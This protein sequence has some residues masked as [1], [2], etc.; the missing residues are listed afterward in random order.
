MELCTRCG[1]QIED[2]TICEC[3]AEAASTAVSDT[4]K[5]YRSEIQNF[6][7][8]MKNRMGLDDPQRNA[9]DRYERGQQIVPDSINPNEGEVPVRQYNIAVL[10][11]LL[12][13]ERAEG[14]LQVTNKR[15]VFRASGISFRGRTTLHQEYAID[16]IAGI[17]ARNNYKLNFL[18]FIF[19][20]LII[21]A[22]YFIISQY[23]TAGNA[24]PLYVQESTTKEKESFAIK[25]IRY[26]EQA[27]LG[28]AWKM[29]NPAYVLSA[30]ERESQAIDHRRHTEMALSQAQEQLGP[31]EE[32]IKR[33]ESDLV[34][35]IL[36]TRRVAVG[37]NFLGETTYR[38]ETY[39]DTSEEAMAEAEQNLAIAIA[40][41]MRIEGEIEQ[42]KA[43]V[44]GAKMAEN[45]AIK[46]RIS[47]ERICA[48]LMTI[49]GILLGVGCIIPF[50]I[51]Y[52]RFGLKLF[53]LCF[54]HFGFQ[55][56]LVASGAKIFSMFMGIS[57]IIIIICMFLFFFRPN[58]VISILN[59]VGAPAAINVRRELFLLMPLEKGIGFAEVIP[60]EESESAIREIC[61]IISD[62]QKLGDFGIE[63]WKK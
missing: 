48:V 28:T 44:T 54:S 8:S 43:N 60:T 27:G 17:E 39:R 6:W 24:N 51:M 42:A 62:I 19:S 11:N 57:T 52:K 5:F 26:R 14:R 33:A 20:L 16:E 21:F 50:F 37:R 7:E 35:G 40:E 63:K 9:S 22:A 2:G 49:L 41:K 36:R 25:Y 59:K 56:S 4:P 61:A 18:Y 29:M 23:G 58:L 12:R 53:I 30:R 46:N 3:S 15:V 47:T 32:A 38:N 13:L 45:E 10:R 34:E 55:L 31:A 1:K